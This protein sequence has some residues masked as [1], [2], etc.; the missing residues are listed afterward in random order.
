[1]ADLAGTGD[2][3][4]NAL[5]VLR[6]RDWGGATASGIG[7]RQ[8]NGGCILFYKVDEEESW[9]KRPSRAKICKQ[10]N[11]ARRGLVSNCCASAQDW[12]VLSLRQAISGEENLRMQIIGN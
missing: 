9:R 1:M 11:F 3:L 6:E 8:F 7:A 2:S 4:L 10:R 12:R 5:R